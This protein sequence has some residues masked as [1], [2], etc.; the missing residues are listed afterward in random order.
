MSM[1]MN[2]RADLY[3]FMMFKEALTVI[4][5]CVYDYTLQVS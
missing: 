4:L 3:Y 5:R 1:C 2:C